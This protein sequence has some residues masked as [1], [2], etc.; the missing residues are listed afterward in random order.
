MTGVPTLT[1][2]DGLATISLQRPDKRNRVE[3][4]D[5]TTVLEYCDAIDDDDSVRCVVLRATGPVWCSGYHLGAL[6]DGHSPKHGFGELCDRIER[7]RVPTVAVVAG[8]VHGGGTDLA[9][10]C[11]FRVGTSETGLVMPA[12]KIGL[13]YYASG[14]RRF[15]ERIGPDA[16]KR[17]FLLGEKIDGSQLLGLGYLTDLV[18][19]DQMEARVE[20]IVAG[21]GAMAPMAVINT[22]SAINQLASHSSELESIQA[23]HVASLNS[24]DHRE[25][26]SAL[27]ERR[28]PRF[29]GK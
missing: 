29:I 5:I 21:V 14:L 27:K 28:P 13:Q 25:A 22:K 3:P 19:F 7:L 12:A 6:A 11:D 18:A 26:M 10:S 2:A 23:R 4:D 17:I 8:S 24:A 9:L 15:V 1:V 20:Q 16:T